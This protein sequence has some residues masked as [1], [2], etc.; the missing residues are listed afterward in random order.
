MHAE[1]PILWP[2]DTKSWLIG[3]DPNAGKY[4]RQKKK[5]VTKMRS[6]DGNINWMDMSLSE[7]PEIVK[8]REAWYATVHRVTKSWAWLSDWTELMA[9]LVVIYWCESRTIKKAERRRIDILKLWG[10]RLFR[11]SWTAKRLTQS[12]LKEVNP[13]YSLEGLILKLKL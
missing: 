13:E 8:D 2:T 5:E 1:A 11:A 9:F 6:L 7:L 10:W 12:I 4:Q 3:K